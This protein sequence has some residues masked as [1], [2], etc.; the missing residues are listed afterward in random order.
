MNAPAFPPT[1][2]A[3]GRRLDRSRDP[4]LDH[5]GAPSWERCPLHPRDRAV[6]Y[7]QHER[8]GYPAGW[9]LCWCGAPTLDGKATCGNARCGGA[10][11]ILRVRI[12]GTK[13]TPKD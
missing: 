10:T 2:A 12:T 1:C 5:P 9:P 7:L 3:C 6:I 4:R 11:E 13:P 8:D